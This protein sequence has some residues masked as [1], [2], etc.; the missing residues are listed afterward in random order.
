MLRKSAV[1][2]NCSHFR[3]DFALD[4]APSRHVTI[5]QTSTAMPSLI[6]TAQLGHYW[7]ATGC[8]GVFPCR[9][10]STALKRRGRAIDDG[11]IKV[12]PAVRGITASYAREKA[13]AKA[14]SR[15]VV[16]AREKPFHARLWQGLRP[17]LKKR[18]ALGLAI[19]WRVNFRQQRSC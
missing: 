15:D 9:N 12:R 6:A 1:L 13:I 4:G 14:I 11:Y 5:A 3:E 18:L 7:P 17:C 8:S 10:C 19:F 2:I 16:I